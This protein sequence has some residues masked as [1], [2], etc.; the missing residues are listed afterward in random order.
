MDIRFNGLRA[1]SLILFALFYNALNAKP[2]PQNIWLECPPNVTINCTQSIS[3]LD[4][5][6]KAWVWENY[7]KKSAP[8]PK[9]IL[10]DLNSCGI[11]KIIR[12]WEYEDIH[13]NIHTCYQEITVQ[14][15]GALFSANDISWPPSTE[16]EGCNP[17]ADPKVL[18]K[19][20]N[21]PVFTKRSCS[22]PL[23]SYS[24]SKF[25]VADGCVKI[26]RLWKVI[27]W[28]QYVPNAKY[29]TGIWTY[30]QVIKLIAK[31]STAKLICPLDTTIMSLSDCNG[32][33]VK[34]DSVYGFSKCGNITKISNNSPYSTSK[35]AN[36]S[37][38]YP[39]GTTSFYF[40][41]EYACGKQITCKVN[42]TVVNKVSPTPYCL[43][44]VI[45]ALMPVDTNRDGIPENG[46]IEVWAKDVDHGSYSKCGYKNLNYSF[47]K[48]IKD[49]SKI[50]TCAELGKNYVELWITDQFGNQSFCKTYIEIQNNNANIPNCKRDSLK[51]PT[52]SLLTVSGLIAGDNKI[53]MENV[54]MSLTD[55]N[56]F[57]IT[58]KID[59]S[60]SI[61]Y[62]TMVRP[63]GTVFY[64]LRRDTTIHV[65]R[66]TVKASITN[67]KLN[68]KNGAYAFQN[69]VLNKEY[70]LFPQVST[71]DLQGIDLNDAISL[72]RHLL[73]VELITAPYKRI[74]ADINTDGKIDNSDFD[75]LYAIL[76][77][78]K[79]VSSFPQSYRF[80]PTI[81]NAA[82]YPTNFQEYL[83]YLPLK[84]STT[85]ANFT[86]IKVGDLETGKTG[87]LNAESQARSTNSCYAISNLNQFKS[88]ELIHLEL[89]LNKSLNGIILNLNPAYEVVSID[90]NWK[91]LN[92]ARIASSTQINGS[93]KM[94]LQIRFNKDL[95]IQDPILQN[96]LKD[97]EHESIQIKSI[98]NSNVFEVINSYPNPLIRSQLYNIDL[99]L[100]NASNLNFQIFDLNGKLLKEQSKIFE[101][102][103]SRWE[104]L[105]PERLSTGIYYY[106][107]SNENLSKQGRLTYFE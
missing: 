94:T 78:T 43:P 22:Q 56:T 15:T 32:T 24:D 39:L 21:Y 62:D 76:N 13:W 98:L 84:N 79:P 5:W 86:A 105:L 82:N 102:G 100:Q 67:S 75:L 1:G 17:N 77:G 36:A 66:D 99:S 49:K 52:G 3:D 101:K 9:E 8:A 55:M 30:T 93:N 46:M 65:T 63:S 74:A 81:Y 89:Q 90:A 50:F 2:S 59:T 18:P 70:K 27:D 72:L 33:Y 6:G 14:G 28:C 91:W 87:T 88:N 10:Y 31:D 34:L 57:T 92:T 73:G 16:L 38:N 19:P 54:L 61:K 45:V 95:N 44:G 106:K 26:L 58:E 12:K 60:I 20:Y 11:G 96:L 104:I 68:D 42:V 83:M 29:P 53:P 40:F 37:G 41:G 107:I 25:T 71:K 80:V 97:L 35:G 7:V 47:S 51:G 23:Y 64:I 85:Q 69:L 48:D 103:I 4:Y